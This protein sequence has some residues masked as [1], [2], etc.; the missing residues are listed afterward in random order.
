MTVGRIAL[1]AAI[2]FLAALAGSYTGRT[3]SPSQKQTGAELHALMHDDVNLDPAQ[4]RQL[5]FLEGNF[6]RRREA[7][8]N[9]L[10]ADNQRLAQA[11][12]AEHVYGPRVSAAVD[13]THHSMGAL[14]K[15]T[16]EHIFA[17]RGILRAEQRTRFDEAV[18]QALTAE[19]R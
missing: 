6:K 12:K 8:E 17:M 11:V 9:R 2:A 10:I 4:K 1:V 18:D 14:Q 16:L 3:L 13:A 7:L 5:D 15:A 19:T